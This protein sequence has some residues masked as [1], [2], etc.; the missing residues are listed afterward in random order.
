VVGAILPSGTTLASPI[1]SDLEELAEVIRDT[2]VPAVF[3][4]SSQPA[5]LAEVLAD[6]VGLDVEVVGLFTESLGPSGSGAATYLEMLNTNT[7]R[8]VE[9][10]GALRIRR[11]FR[12]RRATWTVW[13]DGT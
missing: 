2:G 5:R 8:I 3:A 4:D 13:A 1:A 10:L 7:D 6:E 11:R 9:A 12:Q